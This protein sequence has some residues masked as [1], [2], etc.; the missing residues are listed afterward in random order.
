MVFAVRVKLANV[1]A[2]QCLHQ[3]GFDRG[4]HSRPSASFLGSVVM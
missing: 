1:A 2:V 3:H 4:L